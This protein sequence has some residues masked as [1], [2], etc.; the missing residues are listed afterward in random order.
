MANTTFSGPVRSENGFVIA[1]KNTTTGSVTDSSLHSSANKDIRRYYLEE[2]WKQRPALNAVATAPLTDADATAAANDAIIIA[3]GIASRDFEVLGTS[4]TT[5]LCTFDTTRAGIIITTA[6]TDQNQAII[7]PHL[8]TNQ[9]SWQTVLWG[10]ENSVIW[11]CVVTTAASIADVKLWSGLKLTNDQ[12]IIT[13]ADQAYFKFQ[14]DA[15]NSEAFSDFTLLHFVHSIADTDYISALP[16]T[17]AADTQYHL[18]IEIN[19]DRKAAIYVNGVQYNVTTTSGSTGG[20]AVTTGTE[21][22]AALTND[23]DLIPYI[24]VETG[25]GSAKALKVHAQAISRLIFE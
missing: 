16:I 20:T 2:Y 13:D 3:R 22:T 23:V 21:R 12:L 11:E 4:M 5:A 18:K 19:S 1:N 17:V 6:G 25:A 15:T 24:G 10:T 14:T 9:S 7:A 8:D